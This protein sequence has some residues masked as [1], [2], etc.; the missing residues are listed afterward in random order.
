MSKKSD[1]W[2]FIVSVRVL[3]QFQTKSKVYN[4]LSKITVTKW[5]LG[6]ILGFPFLMIDDCRLMKRTKVKRET[7][8]RQCETFLSKRPKLLFW[9]EKKNHPLTTS[10]GFGFEKSVSVRFRFTNVGAG[11]GS[12]IAH[13]FRFGFG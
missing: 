2:S 10:D 9:C 8:F 4:G 7:D 12:D 6:S 1:R 3:N 13:I 5:F 11:F